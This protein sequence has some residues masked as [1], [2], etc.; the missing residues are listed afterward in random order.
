[1]KIGSE[2]VK[3]FKT[4]TNK[5][6]RDYPKTKEKESETLPENLTELL[7]MTILATNETYSRAKNV[8]KKFESDMCDFNEVRV[9]PAAELE[10]ILEE[11]LSEPARTAKELIKSLNWVVNKFD[12]MDISFLK[13]KNKSEIGKLF[14]N[15]SV[16]HDHAKSALLLLGF[17]VPSMPLDDHMLD[18]LISNEVLPEET[19]LPT[20]KAFIERQMKSSELFTYY[21]QLRKASET[22][23]KKRKTKSSK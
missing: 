18:Y 13:E 10:E 23:D 14:E 9:T 1:M 20:A 12:T 16:C 7:I 22:E 4:L 19:D 8:F 5:L 3:R 2:F 11:Y 21:W 6:K 17:D 15:C